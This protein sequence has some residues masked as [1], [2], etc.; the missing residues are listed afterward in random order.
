MAPLCLL[1]SSVLLLLPLPAG[2]Q[3]LREE[4]MPLA[5]SANHSRLNRCQNGQ[6]KWGRDNGKPFSPAEPK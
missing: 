2:A 6:R 3:L 1:G 4:I 5:A